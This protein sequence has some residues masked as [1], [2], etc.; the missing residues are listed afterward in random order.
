MKKITFI[1]AILAVFT[2]NA[3]IFEDDF[4]SET[5]DA[6][7]FANW[8]SLDLDGDGQFWEVADVVGSPAEPS[9]LDGL[10]ADSDSW[11]G[12]T[13]FSPDNLLISLNPIDLTLVA[14]GML[15]FVMG[16]Y[17]NNGTFTGD[18]LQVIISTENDPTSILA[19]TP[20]F[21]QTVA[22]VTPADDGGAN[23]A[24]QVT[25]D[26]AAFA[27]QSVYIAFRHF[28]T[29]DE[30]S[31]LIDQVVVDGTLS[32]SDVEH[33]NFNH[34]FLSESN[35]LKLTANTIMDNVEIYNILGQEVMNKILTSNNETINVSTFRAG[36][37]VV[38]VNLEGTSQTFK[39]V[40]N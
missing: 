33:L 16:T 8:E 3:Q 39:I 25:I 22:D 23:S 2:V 11:E 14:D 12:G 21:D 9:P 6:T 17:Q 7:T 34:Y 15:T 19:E 20:V 40:K 1:A 26:L 31:V 36:V 32:V 38:R 28:D 30:N 18:R 4:E 10:M 24:T 13:P 37:Y 29:T 5:I 27:G 35:D